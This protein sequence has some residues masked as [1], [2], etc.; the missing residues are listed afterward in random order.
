M[1][2]DNASKRHMAVEISGYRAI[3]NPAPLIG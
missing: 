1:S 3:I 2:V